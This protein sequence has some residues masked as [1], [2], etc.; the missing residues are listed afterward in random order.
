LIGM[1]EGRLWASTLN[2]PPSFQD[3]PLRPA[4]RMGWF[5]VMG[6]WVRHPFRER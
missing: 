6:V 3:A 1:F 2:V 5:V 4:L